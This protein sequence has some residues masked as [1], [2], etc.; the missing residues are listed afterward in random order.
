MTII[1]TSFGKKKNWN[2]PSIICW[3][4]S[5][6]NRPLTWRRATSR[7]CLSWG[8]SYLIDCVQPARVTHLR[9]IIDTRLVTQA[10][11]CKYINLFFSS[12]RRAPRPLLRNYLSATLKRAYAV[13]DPQRRRRLLRKI[14]HRTV[15]EICIREEPASRRTPRADNLSFI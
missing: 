14:Y 7:I 1:G 3:A 8:P 5:R 13:C 4:C 11:A 6:R 15:R 12:T 2:S 10:A 9:G